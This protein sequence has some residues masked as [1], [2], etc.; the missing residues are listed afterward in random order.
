MIELKKAE[1]NVRIIK[2]KK[3]FHLNYKSVLILLI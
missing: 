1:L 2:E 3:M